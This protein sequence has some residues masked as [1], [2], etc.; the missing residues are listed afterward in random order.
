MMLESVERD[1][2]DREVVEMR[3]MRRSRLLTCALSAV[4]AGILVA[5]AAALAV[6]EVGAV[7]DGVGMT[8]PVSANEQSEADTK[9]LT[10]GGT[11]GEYPT[12]RA[13]LEAT[14]GTASRKIVLMGDIQN[15]PGFSVYEESV[16]TLDLNGHDIHLKE[17]AGISVN[18]RL[19]LLDSKAS[20]SPS[21]DDETGE[22]TYDSGTIYVGGDKSVIAATGSSASITFT[23][24]T[25]DSSAAGCVRLSA[26]ATFEMTGGVIN[27]TDGSAVELNDDASFKMTGGV[28]RAENYSAIIGDDSANRGRTQILIDGGYVLSVNEHAENNLAAVGACQVMMDGV[29]QVDSGTIRAIGKGVGVIV[30]Y[31]SFRL[32]DGEIYGDGTNFN[33]ESASHISIDNGYGL[34]LYAA[35]A[36][37]EI[38]GGFI[39]GMQDQDGQYPVPS[40]K[41]INPESEVSEQ[42]VSMMSLDLDSV[43][44]GVSIR[45]GTYTNFVGL[46]PDDGYDALGHSLANRDSWRTVL[47]EVTIP[48]PVADYN[49]RSELLR[50]PTVNNRSY[51][52][53]MKYYKNAE[54]ASFSYDLWDGEDG[55]T[56]KSDYVGV[57][58]PLVLNESNATFMFAGWF[59]GSDLKNA[60]TD[61]NEF[62]YAKFVDYNLIYPMFQ[63]E[64]KLIDD[65]PD[66]DGDSTP[67]YSYFLI[68]SGDFDT[69]GFTYSSE[70]IDS[71]NRTIGSN[72]ATNHIDYIDTATGASGTRYPRQYVTNAVA[73]LMST[74]TISSS[75]YNDE[76]SVTTWWITEDGT[77]VKFGPAK[78]SVNWIISSLTQ[79]SE[80]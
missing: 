68:E 1:Q 55:F 34:I 10:V 57:D 41:V 15:G 46:T 76:F 77:L 35:K 65:N 42:G 24:G 25:L 40:V 30:A 38:N 48:N 44:T 23:S 75:N 64:Y 36:G 78:L 54:Q 3:D 13:A 28:A 74:A 62:A 27:S 18:G 16:V 22:V 67:I 53:Q 9:T 31:G 71:L 33:M 17:D 72:K 69:L 19:T 7:A 11:E 43:A 58:Y 70:G 6:E 66:N 32:N 49:N 29:L 61:V 51:Y 5:P 21:V 50:L 8:E 79:S 2:L 12:V 52:G 39:S 26:M 4:V 59:D 20:V 37:T 45:G 14:T 73:A 47:E 80:G 56:A 60:A 63:I